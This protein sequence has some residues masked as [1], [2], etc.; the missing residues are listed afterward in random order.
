MKAKTLLRIAIIPILIKLLGH[1]IGHMG[2][3][4]PDDPKM[5]TVVD[6]MKSYT[7]QF[8]GASYNMGEY[9]TGYSLMILVVY[10]LLC[11]LLWILSNSF[12]LQ[13]NVA[14]HFIY[15]IAT[16]LIIFSIFEFMYFFP[17]AAAMSVLAAVL[18][19]LSITVAKKNQSI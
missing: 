9:L 3:D 2:W 14:N 8:M 12:N 13:S 19:I 18:M 5:Q 4:K 6:T 17:F 16:T 11:Y 10:A 1:S 15:A 7:G